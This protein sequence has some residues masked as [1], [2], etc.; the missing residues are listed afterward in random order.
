MRSYYKGMIRPLF[1]LFP[2]FTCLILLFCESPR[3]TGY[4][5]DKE[6]DLS[7]RQ[8]AQLDS[9]YESHESKTT[10]EIALITTK[11]YYPDSTILLFAVD[12]LRELGLGRARI[13]NGLLIAYSGT[14]RQ[15][16][17]ATGYGTEKVLNDQIVKRI[18]DS[19]MIPPF[20]A[21]KIYDGLWAGS[22]AIV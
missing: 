21:N 6:N 17:I 8:V 16:F 7:P 18:I 4:V 19:V 11:S 22:K 3:D 2:G 20:K 13:N 9:L 10:N 12:K 14:K 5:F 1:M 15:I